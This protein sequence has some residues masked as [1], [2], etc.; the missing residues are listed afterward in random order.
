MTKKHEKSN[1]FAEKKKISDLQNLHPG[2][3][4]GAEA[5]FE[6][7]GPQGAP[8]EPGRGGLGGRLL[9]PARWVCGMA[10]APSIKK[11]N[12]ARPNALIVHNL[13]NVDFDR[14]PQG[15]VL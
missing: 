10:Q 14:R 7:P 5:D 2:V 8:R 3:F 15:S 12:T 1:F 6:G 11:F 13:Q 4:R 9:G